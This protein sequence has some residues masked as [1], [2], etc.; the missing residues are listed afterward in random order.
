MTAAPAARYRPLGAFRFFLALLVVLQHFQHLLPP[1]AR[2]IFSR[3]GFGAIAVA[4]FFAVSGFVVA[5]ANATF[6]AGRPAAFLTNRALRLVPPYLAAL[7]LS[8]LAQ[9][10]LWRAG[11]LV[12]WDYTLTAPPVTRAS[13]AAGALALVPGFPPRWLGVDFEFIPFVWTLRL[14]VAFY[15]ASTFVMALCI[16]TRTRWVIGAAICAGLAGSAAFLLLAH[17]PGVL[18]TAPMFLFGTSLFLLEAKPS[19]LRVLLW[20]VSACVAAAG[21]ASWRQHGAP[22]LAWQYGVLAILLAAFSGL[23]TRPFAGSLKCLDQRLGDLSYPLYLNHYVV[24]IVA[25][26]C[27]GPP[28]WRLFGAAM[29]CAVTLS[30][31]AEAGVDRPLR[32]LRARIRARPLR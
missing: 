8:A 30:A 9:A 11:R 2:T 20:V 15:V 7:L 13:L 24:G 5:E 23:A 26:S 29:V 25:M 27:A 31:V 3:M 12:L 4:V 14:E 28:D 18:S 6:Y 16:R 21:F 1:T 17:R 19:G 32:A 10:A 22:V